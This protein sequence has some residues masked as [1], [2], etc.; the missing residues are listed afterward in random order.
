[1]NYKKINFEIV[2]NTNGNRI[3]F[4][5][6]ESSS[7]KYLR[8]D[9]INPI[10]LDEPTHTVVSFSEAIIK[11]YKSLLPKER[12]GD[13]PNE[14]WSEDNM[15]IQDRIFVNGQPVEVQLGGNY[16]RKYTNDIV[17]A[18]GAIVHK[19]GDVICYRGTK[20][21]KIITTLT[22][23]CQYAFET[24]PITD[25]FGNPIVDPNTFATKMRLV[26]DANG[27]P[28]KYW[29]QGW[30]PTEVCERMKA[31]LTPYTPDLMGEATPQ[32]P[33]PEAVQAAI[34]NAASA[35]DILGAPAGQAV[36]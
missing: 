28:V 9:C 31:L 32:T 30:S 14:G 18:N 4:S 11:H 12:G 21:P 19:Q 17:D 36:Q 33:N 23:F 7:N 1:M 5:N 20:T 3:K 8:F 29:V 15:P 25:E 13:L 16:V 10:N 34:P 26:R 22:V 27:M 24:E 2:E 6:N 35:S